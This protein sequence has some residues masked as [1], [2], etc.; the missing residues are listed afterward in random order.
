MDIKHLKPVLLAIVATLVLALP[1]TAAARVFPGTVVGVSISKPGK[2]AKKP[3]K[4]KAKAKAAAKAKVKRS[5]GALA[6]AAR[7]PRVDGP[8]R[9]QRERVAVAGG[10]RAQA[11]EGR[12]RGHVE[13]GG[14]GVV[15]AVGIVPAAR[16]VGARREQR[17]GRGRDLRDDGG[18]DLRL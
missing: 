6:A 1:S 2:P 4:A 18:E 16:D 12:G 3:A 15:R 5:K 13:V 14:V 7:P 10:D 17:G 9:L 8:V 11:P